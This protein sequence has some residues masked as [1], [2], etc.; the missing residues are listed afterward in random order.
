MSKKPPASSDLPAPARP[1]PRYTARALP[2]YRHVPGMTPHPTRDPRGHSYEQPRPAERAAWRARDWAA[3]EDWLYGIDLFNAHFFWE[4]HEAW[5][6]LWAAAEPTAPE[7]LALQGLLQVAAALLKVHTR[8][9]LGA[10]SLAAGGLENLRRAAA[11]RPELMGLDLARI[12]AEFD[13]YFEPL[14]RGSFPDLRLA[15]KLSLSRCA[16]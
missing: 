9:L 5:E 7:G 14:K 1:L 12:V 4:A 8:A 10:V 11:V 2:P 16:K 6:R 15:P 13:V 3:L